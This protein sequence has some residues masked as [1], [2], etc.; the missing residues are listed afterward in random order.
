MHPS[1][2]LGFPL[3]FLAPEGESPAPMSARSRRIRSPH[4]PVPE[5]A[6]RLK[7]LYQTLART[8]GPQG[9]WPGR[10]RF[11]VIVG[12]ILTQN[13]SWRNVARAI[14]RLREARLLTPARLAA[15]PQPQLA[16]YIRPAGYYNIKAD[17]LKRF[18]DFLQ[19]RYGL[20]LRRMLARQ[21][22]V[23]RRELL[24]VRGIGPETADSILLYAG[25]IPSFVVDAYTRRIL[26][27]HGL[28]RPGA[29]YDEIQR[30][31]MQALPPDARLF[32]EYHALLVAVGKDF[33][34][35]RP[36]CAGCPLRADLE[37]H[38]P[39][40]ARRFLRAGP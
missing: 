36:R 15:L 23:L 32:N 21:P 16:A 39:A 40:A 9:W 12:A 6:A 18:L 33:C 37:C 31:F 7:G 34:R 35:P 27:R 3:D 29:R 24:A 8:F 2:P 5:V 17:R 13:T 25:G 1:P 38:R 22:S 11:E 4:S 26:G 28:A 30:L 19:G 10:T 20:S 14:Q